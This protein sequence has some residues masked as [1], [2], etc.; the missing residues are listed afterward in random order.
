MNWIGLYP[1]MSM[2]SLRGEEVPLVATSQMS[3]KG[4]WKMLKAALESMIV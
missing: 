4:K 3:M 1:V 2:W